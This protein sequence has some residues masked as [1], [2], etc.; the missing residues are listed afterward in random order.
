M[1][2]FVTRSGAVEAISTSSA[3]SLASAAEA[4]GNLDLNDRIR[5]VQNCSL[6]LASTVT[7]CFVLSVNFPERYTRV[8]VFRAA[9]RPNSGI[10][11]ES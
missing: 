4:A 2:C 11:T 10:L 1:L 6:F 7:G 5:G 8:G 3:D 9:N